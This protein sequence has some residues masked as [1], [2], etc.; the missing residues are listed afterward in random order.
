MA[1]NILKAVSMAKGEF[2]WILGN[3]DILLNDAFKNLNFCQMRTM[4]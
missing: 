1:K 3:D 2:C 4:M